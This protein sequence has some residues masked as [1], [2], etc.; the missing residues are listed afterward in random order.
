MKCRVF[1]ILM[2]GCVLSAGTAPFQGTD[3]LDA[4]IFR[5]LHWRNIGPANMMGR[6]TDVE[7]VP[8]N[9]DL[10]Y[11]GTASG[12]VWKTENGGVTWTPIFDDQPVASIGD[13]AL[14]PGNPDVIYVGTGE[15]NVR[16]SVSFGRGIFKSTD[17]GKNWNFLG[18]EKTER[19]SRIVINPKNPRIVFAGALGK[20]FGSNPE[21]GVFMSRDAGENW[22]K[23]LYIDDKHGVADMDINPAN[24][25]ILFASMWRFERKPWTFISGD[26]EGGVFRSIDGGLTWSKV[27]QGLPKMA[28]RIGVKV[29]PSRPQIV[30]AVTESQEG[31]LYKSRD[32]GISFNKIS[33]DPEIVSRGF[34]YSDL[35]VDPRDEN[36]IYAVSSRLLLSIDGGRS[37]KRISSSTHV[38]FHAL[39]IDPQNPSRM[40]QGQDGGICVSYDRGE[41]WDYVNNFS[42]AQYY[43][44]HADNREPFYFI[45]GGL[46]DNGTW[47]GPSRTKEP[48]GILRADWRMISFGDGFHVIAH[49]DNPDLFISESQGGNIMRTSMITREQQ[50]ISP[51]PRRSDGDPVST[52]PYR[53]NWNTPIIQSPHDKNTVYVGANVVFMSQDFGNTWEKI[54][55][56][57]T[58]DDP[59]KQKTA[60]GPAWPENTTAEYFSTIISLAESPVQPG[61]LWAGTDDG[62]LHVT[63]NGGEDWKNVVNSIPDLPQDSP[64]SHVEPSV[65]SAGLAYCSFDRHMLDDF[66]P[67]IYRTTDF[68]RTWIDIRGNLPK[69][70]YIWV[71]REDPRD[72][73]VIYAGTESGIFVSFSRGGNW[74]K[75][76]MANLPNVA[77]HDILV[78]P[79]KNDLIV[80]THGRGIW[81]LDKI[82]FLQEVSPELL[83]AEPYIFSV[84]TAM[85]YTSKPTRYGIGDRKYRGENPEYGA[86]ITYFLPEEISDSGSIRM[87][88]LNEERNKI[89]TLSDIPRK[90]GLN[91]VAWELRGEQPLKRKGS[92]AD[93]DSFF[94]GLSGPQVLPGAYTAHLV[95]DEK[96]YEKP[97]KVTLDPSL[98]V[99]LEELKIQREYAVKLRDMQSSINQGI[100]SLNAL[101]DQILDRKEAV[102]DQL[103]KFPDTLLQSINDNL[104][105]L[106]RIQKILIKPEDAPFWSIGPRLIERLEGL[107]RSID[108]GNAAPTE[109][110]IEYF[111]SLTGEYKSILDRLNNYF[112]N[113][114]PE[115]NKI[116]TENAVPSVLIPETIRF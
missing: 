73:K 42:V 40:W 9:P 106:S 112:E 109:A 55:G 35:R 80:G 2:L 49:P 116:L 32:G 4:S 99:T 12:G 52:L 71:V 83:G 25:N 81:I 54:S 74:V 97:V 92:E 13:I 16:N 82:A 31:T 5:N 19:I 108:S 21:R 94:G 46:Q 23:V 72:P 68:G 17:G 44:I 18:L 27:A 28:G 84:D 90:K 1:F 95:V 45:S 104:D 63:M 113:S 30:Y 69:D 105:R 50:N 102:Q 111:D 6:V 61:V 89:L 47:V 62:N 20:A 66:Q 64:V 98:S 24:P 88:I 100:T 38:D 101:R 86:L 110:Q 76:H 39:W 51:Q 8:G 33:E 11:V 93:E 15:S 57:L 79:K 91:R 114:A 26:T 78:H 14:E 59:E 103:G 60:G 107:Y 36:R 77:V 53:F 58:K 7:G 41:K 37:F 115:L 67:Y 22:R 10:V 48:M 29:A 70:A 43:Q 75:L 85:R 96:V 87:D 34:Y 3:S 56:E 65:T